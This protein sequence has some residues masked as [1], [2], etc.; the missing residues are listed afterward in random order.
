MK[1]LFSVSCAGGRLTS[2]NCAH[3]ET[4]EHL[5]SLH[6]YQNHLEAISRIAFFKQ[7]SM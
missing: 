1:T 4:R 7:T 6:E 3:H 5:F 2:K